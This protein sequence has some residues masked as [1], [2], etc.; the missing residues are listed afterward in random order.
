ADDRVQRD[1]RVDMRAVAQQVLG[2]LE[3]LAQ[4]LEGAALDVDE[5]V[6]LERGEV[7]RKRILGHREGLRRGELDRCRGE[8]EPGDHRER[9]SHFAAPF[10]A[11]G[12]AAWM[13]RGT[14][15]TTASIASPYVPRSL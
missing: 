3:L 12:V 4:R 14:V 9:R 1:R 2:D 8:H 11:P 13:A 10:A 15:L 7:L 6:R 5:L